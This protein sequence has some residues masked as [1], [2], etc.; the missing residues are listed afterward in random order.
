MLKYVCSS[1]LNMVIKKDK[2]SALHQYCCV[3]LNC[4]R[5]KKNYLVKKMRNKRNSQ[6]YMRVL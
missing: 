4:A 5:R 1:L 2:D 6:V 3:C